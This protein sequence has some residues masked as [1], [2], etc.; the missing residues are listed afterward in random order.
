MESSS[1]THLENNFRTRTVC[2]A[3]WPDKM[4]YTC[5]SSAQEAHAGGS[6]VQ[7]HPGLHSE[8]EEQL[9]L[10]DTLFENQPTNQPM[11]RGSCLR[12]Q[13]VTLP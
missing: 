12:L 10:Q 7:S 8:L 9:G 4:V 1:R 2:E 3:R 13:S 6:R 11:R 5:N